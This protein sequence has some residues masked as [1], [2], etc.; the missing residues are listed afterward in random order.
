[1]KDQNDNKTVDWVEEKPRYIETELGKE[2]LCKHCG[3]Y[4]PVDGDF[5]FMNNRKL[6]D[7]T[8]SSRPDSA[9]KACYSKVY[10]PSRMKNKYQIRAKHE[11][12][13]VA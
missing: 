4:W 1:M 7:G 13:G 12:H 3:D 6:K 5:W 11:K 8:I 2:K 10:R 9:C